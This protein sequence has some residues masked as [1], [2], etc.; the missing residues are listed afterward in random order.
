MINGMVK[1]YLNIPRVTTLLCMMANGLMIKKT[2]SEN[3]QKL[4]KNQ[5]I[6]L[7][8]LVNGFKV[9]ELVKEYGT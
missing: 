1:V 3:L 8:M 9:K 5:I 7:F 6:N 2:D 4:T